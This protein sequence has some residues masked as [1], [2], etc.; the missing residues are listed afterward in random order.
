[1]GANIDM[2]IA[3]W[4]FINSYNGA[5]PSVFGKWLT[6]GNQREYLL[7]TATASQ[8]FAW[9]VSNNGTAVTQAIPAIAVTTGVWHFIAC[10]YDGT[11]IKCSIDGASSGTGFAST[12]FSTDIFDGTGELDFGQA[13]PVVADYFDGT[14]DAWGIWRSTRGNGGALSAA[15]IT[16]LY[17]GG[18]GYS[19]KGLPGALRT[20]LV[21]GW[22]WDG[23]G[24][25]SVAGNHLT[26]VN[27]PTFVAGK[28]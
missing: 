9:S 6:T 13:N 3:G 17:N 5:S 27:G 24:L 22:D 8:H 25:D 1:M 12:A 14:Y 19:I 20:A 23:N 28:V 4:I 16:S 26:P 11:N 2:T 18:I 10:T 7:N 15:Q 21:A